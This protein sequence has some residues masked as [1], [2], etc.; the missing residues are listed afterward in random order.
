MPSCE[1]KHAINNTKCSREEQQKLITYFVFKIK[2]DITC[3]KFTQGALAFPLY[4]NASLLYLV[5][6]ITTIHR[7]RL[8]SA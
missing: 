5:F 6:L 2:M 8:I 7:K 4:V 1:K 3:S